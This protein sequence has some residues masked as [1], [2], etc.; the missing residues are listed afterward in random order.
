[1]RFVDLTSFLGLYADFAAF[2][3]IAY[4]ESLCQDVHRDLNLMKIKIFKAKFG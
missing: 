4:S 3:H 2:F 1:M